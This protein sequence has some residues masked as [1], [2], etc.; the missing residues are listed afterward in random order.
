MYTLRIWG[1]KEMKGLEKMEEMKK[2]TG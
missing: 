2:A 1:V